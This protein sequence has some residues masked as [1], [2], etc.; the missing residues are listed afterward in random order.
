MLKKRMTS[1][2]LVTSMVLSPSVGGVTAIAQA[3]NVATQGEIQVDG[4]QASQQTEEVPQ[5]TAE[6]PKPETFDDAAIGNWGMTGDLSGMVAVAQDGNGNNYLQLKGEKVSTKTAE[7][8]FDVPTVLNKATVS[9]KWYTTAQTSDSRQGSG[10]IQLWQSGDEGGAGKEVFSLYMGELRAA[11]DTADLR[12]SVAGLD[13][14]V[15]TG[16]KAAHSSVH[17]VNLQFDFTTSTVT[18]T[19]DGQVVGTPAFDASATRIDQL[20]FKGEGPISSGRTFAL[21]MGIDDFLLT[22][23]ENTTVNQDAIHALAALPDVTV[24]KE[25]LDAHKHPETVTATLVN[26]ETIE[27]AIDANTWECTPAFNENQKGWYTWTADIIAPEGHPN[28]DNLKVSYR[29]AYTGVSSNE[30][31]YE[32]DFTFGVWEPIVWGKDLDATSGTGGFGLSQKAEDNG[33]G[34]MYAA[35]VNQGGNRGS[36]LNLSEEIVKASTIKF[37]WN[38]INAT[39]AADGRVLFIAPNTSNSYFSLTFDSSYQLRYFTECPLSGA[40]TNQK[41]FEGSISA[42]NAVSTGLSG[43]NKWYTVELS[44]DYTAHTADLT[45]TE[46]DNPSATYTMKD[47]PISPEAKGTKAVV[48]NMNKQGGKSTVEMGIDN[49]T[50]DYTTFGAQDIVSIENPKNVNVAKIAYDDFEFPTE[51]TATLGD[52]NKVTLKVGEWTATPEFDKGKNQ[53]YTW[54]APLEVGDYTNYFKLQATFDMNY[55]TYPY[56]TYA[57]NPKTLELAFGEELPTDF[58]TTVTANMS[59]GTTRTDIPVSDWEP[60]YEFNSAEEGVYVYGAYL[61]DIEGEVAIDRTKLAKNEQHVSGENQ[62]AYKYDVYYR[63]SYF[64][65]EDNYNAYTRSMEYLDRGVYA[66]QNDNGIFVSWRLLV[67]E[68]G[69]DVEFYVTRN[70]EKITGAI[71]DKTNFVDTEGKPGDVYTVITVKDGKMTESDSYTATEQNYLSIPL[72]KPPAQADKDGNLSEYTANDSGVAD[73]DGDG[74]YE[75]VVKW[76]PADA[77][78]S[79]KQNGTFRP[80]HLRL[81]R[82]GRNSAVALEHGLGVPLWCTLESVCILRYGRGR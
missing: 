61:E 52:G 22:Y 47:I 20:V 50:V 78:D 9:F 66:I 75:I 71:T 67:T 25:D 42:A 59:D 70:G 12:Y 13:N 34:Y 16:I 48:L 23:E 63:V 21:D 35:A 81:L 62:D 19:I 7:K 51:V 80:H 6:Q 49:M 3:V 36:R 68:Y 28:T 64:K 57:Y 55:T 54:S 32:E 40:N 79:G 39:T 73:V 41:P 82:D 38:P 26:G 30:H 43:N 14:A 15:V 44:F 72:Q 58:P 27:V 11:G 29:M 1:L 2:M 24:S 56:P 10:S 31:Y 45:I 5:Q 17:D 8:V 69:E 18:I 60:I 37:D 65:S 76:Y 74:Q 77:F 33:N 4:A 46:R 53:V